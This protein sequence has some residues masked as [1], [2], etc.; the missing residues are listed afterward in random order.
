MKVLERYSAAVNSDN[1]AS[2]PRS[3]FSDS[4]VLGAAGLAARYEPLGVALTRLF[5][6]GKPEPTVT[7]LT[8]MAF[9]RAR[10]VKVRLSLLQA[11][12]L[13]KAVLG[14]YRHGICQPC[15]GTAYKLIPGTPALG[16]E[17]SHC[18]GT[19]KLPFDR[20]FTDETQ[21]LARWLSSEIDRAQVA[22]GRATMVMLAP[23]LDL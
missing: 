9:R 10:T 11:N 17:C 2:D 21:G 1:L 5:A 15:G 14:W 12:D 4:D 3:T 22:A 8:E 13:A 20:Q 16:D 7:I 19:G 18:H 23:K 6:D